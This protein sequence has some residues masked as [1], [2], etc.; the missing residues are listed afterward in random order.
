MKKITALFLIF[1]LMV[2]VSGCAAVSIPMAM[3]PST[4]RQV[5]EPILNELAINHETVI[6][7]IVAIDHEECLVKIVDLE[8]SDT[9][10][11]VI[12]VELENK[13]ADRTFTFG[14]R[15]AWINGLEASG[16]MLIQLVP[17]QSSQERIYSDYNVPEFKSIADFTDIELYFEVFDSAGWFSD[18]VVAQTVH[19]Y[20][21]GEE[22]AVKYTREPHVTDRVLFD[23]EYFTA[24][25][26][27][28]EQDPI[29]GFRVKLFLE[30]KT[31]EKLWFITEDE[32]I[33]GIALN[34]WFSAKVPA[35]KCVMTD[36]NWYYFDLDDY[37]I[38]DVNRLRFTLRVSYYDDPDA[39][40]LAK[41]TFDLYP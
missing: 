39:G 31:D 15:G 26:I 35:G 8:L 2:S 20:P 5:Q 40:D 1:S 21:F 12:T 25:V 34:P 27:G 4:E 11:C 29:R 18:V 13:S 9:G 36:I 38:K 37:N 16:F 17:G 41:E 3:T 10:S 24:T 28:Y 33:N 7:E 14:L 19:I 22:R 32:V 30:N 23:N 6:A